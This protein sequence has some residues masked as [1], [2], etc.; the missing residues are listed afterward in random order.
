MVVFLGIRVTGNAYPNSVLRVQNTELLL[1]WKQRPC[2]VC[3]LINS[4]RIAAL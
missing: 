2:F 4:H 3:R 1:L